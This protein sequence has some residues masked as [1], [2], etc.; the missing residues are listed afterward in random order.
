[1]PFQAMRPF[2]GLPPAFRGPFAKIHVS[3]REKGCHIYIYI[4][5]NVLCTLYVIS[6]GWH[7]SLAVLSPAFRGLQFPFRDMFV[8]TFHLN[9]FTGNNGRPLYIYTWALGGLQKR[10]RI[11]FHS[12]YAPLEKIRPSCKSTPLWFT[13]D[14]TLAAKHKC[15]SSRSALLLW[16]DPCSAW[17]PNG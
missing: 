3:V 12:E 13:Q 7:M 16:F 14:L 9:S 17:E 4:Y 1:M 11:M 10:I 8:L 2:A 15:F 5:C 6:L